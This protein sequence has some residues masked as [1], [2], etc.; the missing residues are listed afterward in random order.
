M[1]YT[2]K[3]YS[4]CRRAGICCMCREVPAEED[5]VYCADC[6]DLRSIKRFGKSR[7]R[8]YG[9]VQ[10]D[11]IDPRLTNTENARKLGTS[12]QAIFYWRKKV[13]A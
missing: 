3:R 11:L 10:Y 1:I 8:K 7:H 4:R 12:R 5:R 9:K 6:A 2:D 13:T